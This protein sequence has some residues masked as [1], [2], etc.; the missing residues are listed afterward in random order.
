MHIKKKTLSGGEG[1]TE[2][3][4]ENSQFEK[5]LESAA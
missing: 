4:E 3:I 1:T 5:I 2:I